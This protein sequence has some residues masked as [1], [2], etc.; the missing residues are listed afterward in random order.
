MINKSE[1]F[2]SNWDQLQQNPL[3]LREMIDKL[4]E[5]R[6]PEL[7]TAFYD[8]MLNDEVAK[9]FLNHDLVN[10]HLRISMQAWLIELFSIHSKDPLSVYK[11]Q[12]HVGA[13]HARL[14]IPIVLVTRGARLLRHAIVTSLTGSKLDRGDLIRATTF[15]FEMMELAL[16]AMTDAFIIDVEKNARADESY[17]MFALGQNMSAERERQR[18][19]LLEWVQ[20]ILLR[21]LVDK[22]RTA[23]PGL[24]SSEFGMWL[25]HKAAIVFESA[26][27][28]DRIS[29]HVDQIE[30]A[31]SLK[32]LSTRAEQ[33]DVH[34][35]MKEIEQEISQIKFL[36][37][38]LFDR[39]I[40]VESGRDAL[41][42][43]LNRRHL[44]AVLSRE[45]ALARRNDIPFSVLMLDID[46]FK[47]VNDTYGHAGGDLV[48]QQ[49][50][51]VVTSSVRVGDFIFRYGGEELLILLV[52]IDQAQAI[53]VAES[54]R[55]RI[56]N[57]P[58][59]VGE[60]KTEVVTVSIG[61]AAYNG[62]PDFETILKEAD[63]ALYQAKHAGRN[64][65]IANSPS[66]QK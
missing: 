16:D 61:V 54:I 25:Q 38:G 46:Y 23:L 47:K 43:L 8:Y 1:A 10:Q 13:V 59:R 3:A 11:H 9:S 28:L 58:L 49:V 52:E 50:A 65:C 5:Q 2:I 34:A 63:H 62:H 33:G 20:N 32:L 12:C 39:F 64:R 31:L 22:D 53:M 36:L 66:P 57:E 15:V 35:V 44:P 19:A 27:E 21:L 37:G 45:L 56:E 24:K 48:L 55:Q 30:N 18:A 51:E 40:E 41:T 6:A 29:Q 26:P 60:S 14:Q 42:R 7:A 17:R 4:V